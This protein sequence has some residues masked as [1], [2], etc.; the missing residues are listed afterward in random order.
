MAISAL[1]AGRTLCKLRDWSV[2]NLELQKILYL[3]HMYYLGRL[4]VPLIREEFEAWDYG[5]VIPELYRHLK[6]FG[7]DPVRNVFHW[8][9]P[10]APNTPEYAALST[11][12]VATKGMSAG[13]LVANTHWQ[14]GAW[15]KFYHPNIVGI[16]IPNSEILN[17]YRS[18][19]VDIR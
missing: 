3:A 16:K 14:G 19:F 7:A 11:F 10:V 17:E 2:S 1:S 9:D 6:G 13:Q 12:A 5:P 8:I 18:R 15:D 4:G